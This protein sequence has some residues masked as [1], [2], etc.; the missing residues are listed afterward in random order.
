[1]LGKC[2]AVA[3]HGVCIGKHFVDKLLLHRE[4]LVKLMSFSFPKKGYLF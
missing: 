4:M 2:R 3:G 1:M